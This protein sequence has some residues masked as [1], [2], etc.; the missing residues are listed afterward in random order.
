MNLKL[1]QFDPTCKGNKI[2]KLNRLDKFKMSLHG[3]GN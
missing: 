3:T 2:Y 1:Q